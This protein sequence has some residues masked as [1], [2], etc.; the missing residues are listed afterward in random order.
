MAGL[1]LLQ[2]CAFPIENLDAIEMAIEPFDLGGVRIGGGLGFGMLD[3]DLDTNHDGIADRQQSVLYGRVLGELEFSEVGVGVELIL[4]EYGPILARLSAGVPVPIGG[5]IGA[6]VGVFFFGVGAA[7]GYQVGDNTGFIVSGFEGGLVF[8]EDPLPV[9]TD[10]AQILEDTIHQ[11]LDITLA[12][13]L[14]KLQQVAQDRYDVLHDNDPLNDAPVYT[15]SDGFTLA[16]SGVLT[17]RYVNGLIALE[18]T[19]GINVGYG[20]PAQTGIQ[21]FGYGDLEL[22]GI[23]LAR[24]GV[25]LDVHL[26][27]PLSPTLNAAFSFPGGQ[28][29]PLRLLFPA[30]GDFAVRVETTGL[31]QGAVAGL[32]ALLDGMA[33]SSLQVGGALFAEMANRVA[34]KLEQ[35]R[36]AWLAAAP[37]SEPPLPRLLRY[38]LALNDSATITANQLSQPITQ[39]RMLFLATARLR[40]TNQLAASSVTSLTARPFWPKPC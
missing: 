16:F 32:R 34:Q 30:T 36:Q 38:L 24:S 15:W 14:G 5:L 18:G 27:D 11:P 26:D 20:S 29:N 8:G 28:N 13:V 21:L 40:T 33:K 4:T 10:P 19:F 7:A 17:N 3:V 23:D 35:S 37:G 12:N 6:V 1:D 2:H 25:L 31:F 22:S 9:I 39:S